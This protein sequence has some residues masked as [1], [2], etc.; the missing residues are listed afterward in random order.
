MIEHTQ[1]IHG[2]LAKKK[3]FRSTFRAPTVRYINILRPVINF[4][5]VEN[6]AR[7]NFYRRTR[8]SDSQVEIPLKL[9]FALGYH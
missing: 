7:G 1:H 5:R 6:F 9:V 3:K 8:K 4:D 2:I